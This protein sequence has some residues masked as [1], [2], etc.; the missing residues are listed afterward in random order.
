LIYLDDE[1]RGRFLAFLYPD[2]YPDDAYHMLQSMNAFKSGGALGRGLGGSLQKH[3]F[4]PEAHTDFIYAVLGEELGVVAS[5]LVLALFIGYFVCGL[6]IALRARDVFGRYLALGVSLIV[7]IQA[8]F[9]IAV[10]SGCVPTKG[11]PLPFISYGGSSLLISMV[12]TG[13]LLSV[14]QHADQDDQSKPS[15][16]VDAT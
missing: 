4:L 2:K 13:L 7:L 10:V 14:A 12:L 8:F 9:N 1:R 11:L 5:F 6:T 16:W 15:E 3:A